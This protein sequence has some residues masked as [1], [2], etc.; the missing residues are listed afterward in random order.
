MSDLGAAARSV[1]K[2]EANA[3]SALSSNVVV[4]I[5][6]DIKSTSK[7]WG[8]GRFVFS[9]FSLCGVE[10]LQ[11][12]KMLG[13]GHEGGFGLRPSSSRQGLFCV[14]VD[15]T[16]ANSF[17]QTSELIGKYKK[18]S[19]EFLSVQ[20]LPYSVKGTWAGQSLGIAAEV[21]QGQPVAA[22]TRA[23]IRPTKA[24]Q[25]WKKQPASERS[26]ALA[27]GCVMATGVGE[28]PVFRQATFTVWESVAHMDAYARTGAH[29]EAIKASARGAFFSESMFVRFVPH[30][31]SGVYKGK[32]FGS[33]AA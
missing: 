17:L 22:L 9:R 26:L 19:R 33:A 16:S 13:S 7:W 24:R 27:A 4:L 25:F 30:D 23:S 5:L 20:L 10:G 8:F 11:F 14:F 29:M 18:H 28:A 2:T 6:A 21:V 32:V 12:F 31:I 15:S 1:E 3:A